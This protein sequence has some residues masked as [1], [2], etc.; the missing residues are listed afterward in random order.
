M[1]Q[2]GLEN[3]KANAKNPRLM[4]KF[5]ADNLK[6]SMQEFGDLSGVVFNIQTQQLVGGHQRIETFKRMGSSKQIVIEHRFETP[7]SVGTVAVGYILYNDERYGYRE[8]DWPLDRETAANIAANR[9]QGEFDLDKLAEMDWWL[10]ENN[11]DLLAMTGQSDDEISKLLNGVGPSEIEEDEAPEVDDQAPAI[12]KYGEVYQLGRHR[13]M[14]GNSDTDLN[15]LVTGQLDAIVTD[16]PY[17]IG[18]AANPVRQKHEKSDWDD[19]PITSEQVLQL[20]KYAPKAIIWGGNYFNLPPSKGFLIWDK[21]QPEDFS[22]AMCEMAWTNIDI[23]A[24]MHRQSVTSYLKEH[25]T[26]KPV[27]LIAWSM[28]VYNVGDKILDAYGGSGTTLVAC[29]QTDRTCYMMELSPKYVDVIRK[30]Y[31]RH[32]N[33][34][35]EEGWEA[36]TPVIATMPQPAAA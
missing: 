11:P 5:D 34:D 21:K 32:V 3:L 29:E 23:P 14:C 16:P 10:K 13:L 25:P 1:D 28:S 8:V 36:G 27:E 19:A 12:S 20:L 22:L 7:N 6:K 26:Q 4:N 2:S 9:I 33:N 24:K 17:G 35:N 15:I 18:I 30:R 31:W